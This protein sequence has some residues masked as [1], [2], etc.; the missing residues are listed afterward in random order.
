MAV[1]QNTAHPQTPDT[2]RQQRFTSH[3]HTHKHTHTNT[4]TNTHTHTHTH[5]RNPWLMQCL[6]PA[7]P[8]TR[9]GTSSLPP[10]T[11]ATLLPID[12]P[13]PWHRP[14]FPSPHLSS[15]LSSRTDNRYT[16]E[17]TTGTHSLVYLSS[18]HSSRSR[19]CSRLCHSQTPS[20]PDTPKQPHTLSAHLAHAIRLPVALLRIQPVLFTGPSHPTAQAGRCQ[21]HIPGHKQVPPVVKLKRE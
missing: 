11:A 13:L 3:T 1:H 10:S 12:T 20:H 6:R 2:H 5:T 18:V 15:L 21:R 16:R 4:H 8:D 17:C 14:S 7:C 9:R 19:S